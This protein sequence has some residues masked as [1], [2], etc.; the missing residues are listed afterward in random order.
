MNR[1]LVCSTTMIK[2]VLNILSKVLSF[3]AGLLFGRKKKAPLPEGQ[4]E[5]IVVDRTAGNGIVKLIFNRPRKKNAFNSTMYREV[6]D[7][8]NALSSD[9]SVKACIITGAGD[10]YSS[11]NDLANF[12]VIM[13][14]LSMAK[15]A[16]ATCDTFVSSFIN[17]KKPLVAVVNGPAI[18]IAATTLGL[19][20]KIFACDRAYFKTPFAELGQS[21]EGC[22]SFV[23]PRIMGEKVAHEVL[24]DSKQL[25]ATSAIENHFVHE[26]H[27]PGTIEAAAVAY[28]NQLVGT[29][30]VQEVHQ[31]R[32]P[33][34][35]KLVEKLHEVNQQE[36]DVLEK[37]WV[38]AECFLALATFLESRN[39]KLAAFVLR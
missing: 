19:C 39:M 37:K 32:W 23:F 21:P 18:G 15:L 11:G 28:C 22:S 12:S 14:P 3:L 1:N 38:C 4:Y 20:D 25:T 6:S 26:I 34:R 17:F 5:T 9:P 33:I 2:A 8:L 27:P 29:L 36:L 30:T 13:H 7:T 35:E 10:F 31:H 24:W 16:R